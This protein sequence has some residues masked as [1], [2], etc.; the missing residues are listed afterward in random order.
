V[1]LC[2]AGYTFPN[3]P[4]PLH[5]ASWKSS[6]PKV[7]LS[8]EGVVELRRLMAVRWKNPPFG[9]VLFM[10]LLSLR[11]TLLVNFYWETRGVACWDCCCLYLMF[12]G[13]LSSKVVLF[14]MWVLG[15]KVIKGGVW[16]G[17]W[18]VLYS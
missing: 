9:S 2:R 11:L 6:S 16:G 17:G 5:G 18:R 8:R 1:I 3:L 15:V 7:D 13:S 12:W 10:G 14:R 4:S